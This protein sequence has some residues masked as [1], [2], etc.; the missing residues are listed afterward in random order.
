MHVPASPTYCKPVGVSST[1]RY[2]KYFPIQA[3]LLLGF[4]G[5][6]SGRELA[7]IA[8]DTGDTGLIPGSGSSPGGGNGNPFSHSCLENPMDR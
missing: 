1:P 4:P 8:G 6:A 7:S 5:G 2:I 3:F